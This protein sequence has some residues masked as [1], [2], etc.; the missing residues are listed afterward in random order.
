M[1]D[2]IPDRCV[3]GHRAFALFGQVRFRRA[4]ADGAPVMVVQLGEREAALPLHALQHELAI[5][6]E[7]EDGRMLALI[8]E[9]LDYVNALAPG[10]KLPAEVVNGSASWTP[11]AR[12]LAIAAARLR[13]Q[14][15]AWLSPDAAPAGH[16]PDVVLS[17]DA[18]PAAKV[19]IQSAFEE[20]AR[21]LGLPG[22]D[23]VVSLLGELAGELAYIEALREDL[24]TP[25][26]MLAVRLGAFAQG[27]NHDLQRLDMLRQVER[28][29]GIAVRQIGQRFEEVDAQTGEVM[30]AL[31]NVESQIQFIRANRDW[32]YR[33]SLGWRPVLD[34]WAATAAEEGEQ[35]W[36]QITRSYQFL[37]PRYM[38][39]TE[40]QTLHTRPRVRAASRVMTW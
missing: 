20:A 22:P 14:L 39:V 34:D 25:V 37:A 30:A 18:D 10:D 32:L 40:W 38:P 1:P 17:L 36:S 29:A 19:K 31:R 2:V 13:V 33:C 11:G 9:S 16:D 7:S 12:H 27:R 26:R 23:E 4:A 21:V 6:D 35:I 15:M 28:L 3:L 5:P 24:L 8:A